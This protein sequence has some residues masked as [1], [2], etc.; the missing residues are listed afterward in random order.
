MALKRVLFMGLL[1]LLIQFSKVRAQEHNTFYQII[2]N[3][4]METACS[5]VEPFS[6]CITL[7]LNWQEYRDWGSTVALQTLYYD[8]AIPD[9]DGYYTYHEL[10]KEEVQGAAESALSAWNGII[11]SGTVFNINNTYS[12]NIWW[13]TDGVVRIIANN[14]LSYFLD[15]PDAAG[16]ALFSTK[17][18]R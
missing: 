9:E 6:S 7:S 11:Q 13:S 5:E 14:D 10:T 18:I 3:S 15:D 16:Y 4:I 8:N 12:N 2:E 17:I 1:P